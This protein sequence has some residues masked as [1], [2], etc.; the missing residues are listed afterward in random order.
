MAM[1]KEDVESFHVG[2]IAGMLEAMSTGGN[3]RIAAAASEGWLELRD[4]AIRR[5]RETYGALSS[6]DQKKW[7]ASI[8]KHVGHVAFSFMGILDIPEDEKP[9]LD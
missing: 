5:F 3:S 9:R 4:V 7:V 8:E 6:E 2:L 1:K